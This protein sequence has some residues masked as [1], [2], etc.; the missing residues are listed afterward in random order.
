[1]VGHHAASSQYLYGVVDDALSGLP[2]V[3]GTD[4]ITATNPSALANGVARQINN[5]DFL[6]L[7]AR[8]ALAK[9]RDAFDWADRGRLLAKL[10]HSRSSVTP[11]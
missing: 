9:C 5:L 7:A 6:N 4:A 1:M 2:L 8:S 3:A 10:L 11:A